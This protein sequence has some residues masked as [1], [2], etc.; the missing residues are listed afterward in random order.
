[1]C[2]LAAIR[3]ITQ[4]H[5]YPTHEGTEHDEEDRTNDIL[6]AITTPFIVTANNDHMSSSN[7]HELHIENHGMEQK[8]TSRLQKTNLQRDSTFVPFIIDNY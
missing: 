2:K 6:I 5:S 4:T 7:M 8:G 3:A 1:M